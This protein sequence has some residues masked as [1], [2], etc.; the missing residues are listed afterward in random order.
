MMRPQILQNM[1]QKTIVQYAIKVAGAWHPLQVVLSACQESF[2]S[3]IR[4]VLQI[5]IVKVT[6]KFARKGDGHL[7]EAPCVMTAKLVAICLIKQ[8]MQVNMTVK[9]VALSVEK[10]NTVT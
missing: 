6:A 1:T 8:P 3:K 9:T 5:M 2:F 7:K 10:G 4:R